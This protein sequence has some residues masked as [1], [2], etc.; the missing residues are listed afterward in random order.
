LRPW[1][2]PRLQLLSCRPLIGVLAIDQHGGTPGRIETNPGQVVNQLI[3]V[4]I[5]ITYD[6]IVSLIILF[7][8]NI[9]AGLRVGPEVER[10]GP[11]LALNRSCG[12]ALR[13]KPPLTTPL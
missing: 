9:T 6:A 3:G 4:G 12:T 2:P 11:D 8:I 1:R 13:V 10:D 7:L 5:V